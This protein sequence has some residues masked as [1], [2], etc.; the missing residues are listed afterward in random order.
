MFDTVNSMKELCGEMDPSM[1]DKESRLC[2][3]ML[4][5]DTIL[6]DSSFSSGTGS[7]TDSKAMSKTLEKDCPTIKKPKM[8]KSL[9]DHIGV[10]TKTFTNRK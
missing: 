10:F 9:T 3:S 7:R 1:Y 5:L 6:E 4:S 2:K 8:L